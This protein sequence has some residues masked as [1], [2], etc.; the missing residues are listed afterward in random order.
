MGD[1]VSMEGAVNG[2]QKKRKRPGRKRLY[3][4]FL[5][6][7]AI[8]CA[9][10][11]LLAAADFLLFG[12]C[13]GT[14]QIRPANYEKTRI[15]SV[16]EEIRTGESGEEALLPDTCRYGVYDEEGNYLYG[17]LEGEESAR[18]IE[19]TERGQALNLSQT[20]YEEIPRENGQTV[21]VRYQYRAK[22][23][24]PALRAWLPDAEV[25]FLVV[26]LIAFLLLAAGT[27][28]GFGRYLRRRLTVLEEMTE[29]IRREDLGFERTYSDIR[30][31]DEIMDSL[32][33]MKEALRSSL[34]EQWETERRKEEEVAALAHDIKT[35]LTVIRGNAELLAEDGDGQDN[36]DLKQD[37]L[38]HVQSIEQYLEILQETLRSGGH[39]DAEDVREKIPVKA[40]L[41]E[42][43]E[44]AE[45]LAR[46]GKVQMESRLGELPE[47]FLGSRAACGRAVDNVLSNAVEYAGE[48]GRLLVKARSI[49]E[50]ERR[51]LVLEIHDSGPGFSE[52]DLRH[53][54]ERFYQGEES[55]SRKNH[56]GMGLYI[57]KALAERQG[58]FLR[59]ENS[60]ETGGAKVSLFF[61]CEVS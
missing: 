14:G 27:A 19:L 46:G 23:E 56:Y 33:H 58:G 9:G 6:Y 26:I 32:F 41:E 15:D 12:A 25:L 49:C 11:L 10:T 31:V 43:C 22:F 60:G 51:F 20:F 30:E 52:Q 44:R 39:T 42:L 17:N 45:S 50:K 54:T 4:V 16:R 47:Y 38:T 35:P 29:K 3:R 2:K 7:L 40:W 5:T 48:G 34:E 61:G 18:A 55:R 8:F 36:Q 37:I 21:I 1:R 53:G 28:V 57:A 24:S 59:L 13:L